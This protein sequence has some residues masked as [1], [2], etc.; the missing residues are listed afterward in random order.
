MYPIAPLP[1][2]LRKILKGDAGGEGKRVRV[3]SLQRSEKGRYMYGRGKGQCQ[4]VL[5]T[6]GD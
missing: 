1:D 5:R 3:L 2:L 4:L 6:P